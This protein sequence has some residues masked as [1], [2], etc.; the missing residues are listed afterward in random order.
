MGFKLFRKLRRN[1]TTSSLKKDY[2]SDSVEKTDSDVVTPQTSESTT[3]DDNTP[4]K[5]DDNKT[6]SGSTSRDSESILASLQEEQLRRGDVTENQQSVAG[7]DDSRSETTPHENESVFPGPPQFVVNDAESI[8]AIKLQSIAR[9][10]IV[11]KQLEKD[12]KLTESMRD[13]ISASQSDETDA[14]EEVAPISSFCGLGLL[15]NGA[16]GG[17]SKSSGKERWGCT[18]KSQLEM[19]QDDVKRKFLKTSVND[20]DSSF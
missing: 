2:D 8:A 6:F 18:D 9:R 16:L 20:E 5:I 10:N 13:K 4:C 15:F 19:T 12:G 11:M 1:R 7:V 17:E 14:S 3:E